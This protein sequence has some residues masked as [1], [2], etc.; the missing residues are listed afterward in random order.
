M[1]YFIVVQNYLITPF[2]PFYQNVA[3]SGFEFGVLPDA[4]VIGTHSPDHTFP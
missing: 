1:G 3:A 2:Y 4:K